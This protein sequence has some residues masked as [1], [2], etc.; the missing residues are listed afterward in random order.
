MQELL[1]AIE[2]NAAVIRMRAT[3]AL[4]VLARDES[5][6]IPLQYR[7]VMGSLSD[8]FPLWIEHIRL[9]SQVEA[10]VSPEIGRTAMAAWRRFDEDIAE[11]ALSLEVTGSAGWARTPV[12]GINSLK[13]RATTTLRNILCQLEREQTIVIP[14]LRRNADRRVE[15]VPAAENLTAIQAA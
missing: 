13:F 1:T 7:H 12:L 2:R 4:N 14:L 5:I 8:L 15:P 9:L 3:K 10:L 6:S 11:T